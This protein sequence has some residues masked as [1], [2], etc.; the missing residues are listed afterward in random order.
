MRPGRRK[1]SSSR[2]YTVEEFGTSTIRTITWSFPSLKH[3]GDFLQ[4]SSRSMCVAVIDTFETTLIFDYVP[5][6]TPQ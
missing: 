2:V 3:S 6:S 5:P 1:S 4:Y